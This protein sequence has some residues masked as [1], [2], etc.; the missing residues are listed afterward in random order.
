M[1][2]QKVFITTAIDYTNEIIHIGH[3]YQ[4][5]LADVFSRFYRLLGKRVFFI[6]GTDEH[7][8]NI[9]QAAEEHG[10]DVKK[11]VDNISMND[12]KE[13]DSLNI[14]YDRFIRTTDLDHKE[15][16]KNFWNKVF[17]KGDIYLKNFKGLY[18]LGCESFKTKS[19][20]IDGRCELHPTKKL[21]EISEKNY[22][23]KW[24]KYQTFLLNVLRDN[25][26]FILPRSKYNEM[27]K[28]L[29]NPLEDISISRQNIKWGIPVPNDPSQII[30]VWFDALINYYTAGSKEGFWNKDTYIIHFLGKDNLRWH[31]LLW[32]A[33]LKSADL[34]TPDVIY[35]HNFLTSGG[36][37]ISKSFGN[38]LRPTEL[39]KEFGV[40]A[41]RYYLLKNGPLTRD[42]DISR[43]KV[44][45]TY[46]TDLADGLG[47]LIQRVAK[48]CVKVNYKSK[49]TTK[50]E[51]KIS[52]RIIHY[53]NKF[54]IDE[55]IKNIQKRVT[56]ENQYINQKKPWIQKGKDL[57]KTIERCVDNIR[58]IAYDLQLFLP[59]VASEIQKRFGENII[60]GEPL[61]P[62]IK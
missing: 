50:K 21:L 57:E 48:I 14:S 33:M 56:Q 37:K 19:E 4:K 34:K 6:T 51:I 7:G 36:N 60:F 26:K 20:I 12:K 32:P 18:C 61:F 49:I 5:V 42:A 11:Y 1:G 29:D 47:N 9:E 16:V 59:T 31:A 13:I 3:A 23:F 30:Y 41:V 58:Q 38:I 39:V 27:V 10:L 15:C 55:C 2:K 45:K 62:K 40:D 52:P 28:F 25:Q 35:A 43:E 24:S 44:K 54:R 46:N 22:F 8:K 53:F 17:N